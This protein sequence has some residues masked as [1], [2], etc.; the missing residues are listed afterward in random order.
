MNRDDDL[1][2][3]RELSYLGVLDLVEQ[4]Q[5][6]WSEIRQAQQLLERD[7]HIYIYM[8]GEVERERER[9]V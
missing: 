4:A 9:E 6:P 5:K 1:K 7:I 8:K 3:G 2:K